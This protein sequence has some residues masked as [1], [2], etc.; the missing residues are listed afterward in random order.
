MDN[1]FIV[2]LIAR[3]DASKTPDDLKKI[4]QQLNN[5]GIN[6][7]ATIDTAT[8]KQELQ[9]YATQMQKILSD[10]GINIDTG[11]ITASINKVVKDMQSV[12]AKAGNIGLNIDTGTYASKVEALIAKTQKWTDTNGNARISTANLQSALSS[13]NSA[14][15]TLT[16]SGGNTEANQRALIEAERLLG[17]QIQ[18]VTNKV[19]GMNAKF[20][21]DT[22]VQSLLQK[23]QMFYDKN[24]AAHRQWGAQLKAGI[25]ELGSGADIPIEK[26]KQLQNQLVNIG[27]AARQA[28]KLGMS[29]FD[30]MK[31]GM[32]KFSYWTSSTMVVMKVF[33][34]VRGAITFAKDMDSALTNI[35]YTMDVTSDRLADIGKSSLDVA[36][37]LKTSAKNV[38]SAVTTYANAN[39]TADSI[40]K[41]SAPTIMLSNVSGLDTGKTTDILQGT[42]HQFDLEDTEETLLHVSDVLQTVSQSMAVDFSKGIQEMAE[43]IQVSGSVA[44]D[45]GYDLEAYTALLGNLIEKTR[46]SGS[47]LGRSLRT[48]FVRTTKASTSALA[49]GEVTEDDLSNA[50]TALRR[51]NIQVRDSKDSFREFDDI[52]SD[53]YYKI[54]DLSEVDLANIAYEVAG[55]RQTAVFKVMVK[56]WGDYLKLAEKADDAT[57]TTYENQEKYAESLA[58]KM[59][60]LSTTMDSAWHNII[61]AEDTGVIVDTLQKIADAL[62]WVTEKAGLLGTIGIGAGLFAGFKNIGICV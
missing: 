55:T 46:E 32:S 9:N 49:G 39:E 47:V 17:L 37:D 45:A 28:G 60:D 35:N 43:G 21:T 62:D 13:L 10:I 40:L 59:T 20:A 12:S 54:D 36:K 38:L 23:Y 24:T 18:D 1:N 22:S 61:N 26:Y 58:A 57:G 30:K 53:L 34:E 7:K 8:S 42:I 52:M 4:E 25:A 31:T 11:K 44:K 51:V 19:T 48:M 16:N 41:K 3:L 15:T 5:K 56:S 27:N 2:Q 50:E 33:Q 14:Y 6:L 29:W